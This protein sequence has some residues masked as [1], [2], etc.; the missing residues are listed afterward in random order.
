M[1]L[2]YLKLPYTEIP[3]KYLIASERG[4]LIKETGD[5]DNDDDDGDDYDDWEHCYCINKAVFL[6]LSKESKEIKL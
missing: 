6:N 1:L 5:N 3:A 2:L 4:Y